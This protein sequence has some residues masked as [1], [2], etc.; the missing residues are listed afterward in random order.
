MH[1]MIFILFLVFSSHFSLSSIDIGENFQAKV[2]TNGLDDTVDYTQPQPMIPIKARIEP[3]CQSLI[4]KIHD[5][6]RLL[7]I[8]QHMTHYHDIL[9]ASGEEISKKSDHNQTMITSLCLHI[10]NHVTKVIHD[11]PIDF[12]VLIL[13]STIHRISKKR[14]DY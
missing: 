5:N 1:C 8:F 2:T 14:N 7:T 12:R 9:Y 13:K 4:E 3:Q 10:L 6:K 11:C